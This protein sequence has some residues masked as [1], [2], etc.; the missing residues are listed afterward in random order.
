MG[1]C[2]VSVKRDEKQQQTAQTRRTQIVS[3]LYYHKFIDWIGLKGLRRLTRGFTQELKFSAI[4]NDHRPVGPVFCV[5]WNFGD[6]RNDVVSCRKDTGALTNV[7]NVIRGECQIKP[8][9]T[10]PNVTCFP[11]R[12]GHARRETKN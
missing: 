7:R 1:I 8:E 9:T 6:F 10:R 2:A 5:H 11:S 4:C 12:W 3:S